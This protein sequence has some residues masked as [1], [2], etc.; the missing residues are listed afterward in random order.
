MRKK[1]K[2]KTYSPKVDM[3]LEKEM[4]YTHLFSYNIWSV[5]NTLPIFMAIW[6]T[7]KSEINPF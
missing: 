2:K 6:E 5:N 7:K 1:K 4:K 3:M